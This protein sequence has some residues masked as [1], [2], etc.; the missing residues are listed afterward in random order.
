METPK[1]RGFLFQAVVALSLLLIGVLIVLGNWLLESPA[2][3][4]TGLV[5]LIAAIFLIGVRIT[6]RVPGEKADRP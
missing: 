6:A 2:A 5:V 1:D 4:L 3:K